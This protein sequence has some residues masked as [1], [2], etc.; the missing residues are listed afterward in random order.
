MNDQ[1]LQLFVEDFK[2]IR[3]GL[4]RSRTIQDLVIYLSYPYAAVGVTWSCVRVAELVEGAKR[5]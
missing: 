3:C 2:P 1:L 4:Y 5:E